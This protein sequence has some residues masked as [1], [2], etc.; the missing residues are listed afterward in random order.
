MLLA[1]LCR[2]VSVH[3]MHRPSLS[4][5]WF[6]FSVTNTDDFIWRLVKGC[7]QLGL[8]PDINNTINMV[9]VDNVARY[10][11]L[12]ALSL[13]SSPQ[14]A[15]VFHI[16]AHPSVRFNDVLSSLAKYGYATE[17]MG[18][19]QWRRRL[20]QHVI[21]MQDNALFPLLHF[22]L[23][24]LPTSTKGP[25]LNDSNT[26]V[27]LQK[28]GEEFGKLVDDNLMGMYL[29]WLVQAKFLEPPSSAGIPLPQLQS[30]FAAKAI[31]R[32]G[33]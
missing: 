13:P 18:Y 21:E 33:R 2:E 5:H 10:T 11:A 26:A 27:L 20:E 9:P 29:A 22:V 30:A 25:E 6:I 31:G 8:V 3:Q 23:D 4:A 7:I 32:T 16:T 15:T 17:K 1:T 28:N 24:D 12:S 19:L 14:K